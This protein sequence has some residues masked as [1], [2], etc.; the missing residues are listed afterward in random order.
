M[1]ST[2]PAIPSKS[3]L[4]PKRIGRLSYFVRVVILSVAHSIAGYLINHAPVGARFRFVLT[5]VW[6]VPLLVYFCMFVVIPR[7]R[8]FGLP[9]LAVLLCFV[10]GINIF[11]LLA[12]L[13]GPQNYWQTIRNRQP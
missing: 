1:E 2:S 13:F 10:P 8:D 4:L 7:L 11:V 5:V 12:L 9:A 3:L 6:V